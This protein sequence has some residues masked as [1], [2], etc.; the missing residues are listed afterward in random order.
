M[1]LNIAMMMM[2]MITVVVMVLM[3]MIPVVVMVLMVMITVVVMVL[4]VVTGTIHRYTSG[5]HRAHPPK[6]ELLPVS[7][8][9][10]VAPSYGTPAA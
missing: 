3:V 7:G 2:M 5:A 9:G 4:M 10:P 8:G 6:V 1:M